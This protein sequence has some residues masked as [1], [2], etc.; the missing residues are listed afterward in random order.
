MFVC[1]C[2][3]ITDREIL[4]AIRLGARD[5]DDLRAGLG[6]ATQCGK[7]E[8]CAQGL[9]DQ[10]GSAAQAPRPGADAHRQAAIPPDRLAAC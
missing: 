7:C 5:L 9:L 6:V 1:V 3:S 10:E 8:S 4:Q 2:N